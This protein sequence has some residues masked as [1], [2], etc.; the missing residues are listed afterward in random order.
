MKHKINLKIYIKKI[1]LIKHLFRYFRST[2][3]VSRNKQIM[4]IE[5]GKVPL[6][7]RRFLKINGVNK[8]Q[9]SLVFKSL[10]KS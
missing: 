5:L 1:T 6:T 2:F 10:T 8:Q 7:K 4:N 9:K 3:I